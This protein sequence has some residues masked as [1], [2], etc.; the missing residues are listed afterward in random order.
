V[1]KKIFYEKVGRRY[2]PVREYDSD[3]HYALPKGKHMILH[4]SPGTT[5]YY[6]NIDPAFAPV[7]AA[8]KYGEDALSSAILKATEMRPHEWNITD[9]QRETWNAFKNTFGD[10]AALIEWPSARGAAEEVIKKLAEEAD[11]MLKVP[12]VKLAYEQFM[13]VYKLT[14]DE[15]D[16]LES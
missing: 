13:M 3:I 11:K 8:A 1:S 9:E 16:E 2:V 4:V 12:A 5:S 6:H 7:L 10:K 15:H 14:K